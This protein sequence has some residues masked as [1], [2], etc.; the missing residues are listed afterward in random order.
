LVTELLAI[1]ALIGRC[2]PLVPTGKAGGGVKGA[3]TFAFKVSSGKPETLTGFAV[4]GVS[5]APFKGLVQ[6]P[7]ATPQ[8]DQASVGLSGPILGFP[9]I[10]DSPILGHCDTLSLKA[11]LALATF[12]LTARRIVGIVWRPWPI[13]AAAEK[14][15]E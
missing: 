7:I 3:I 5:I 8:S 6:R 15:Q 1:A 9:L 11:D 13:A 12:L 2:N 4:E 14:G 10:R